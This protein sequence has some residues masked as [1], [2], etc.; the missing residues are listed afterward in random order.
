MIRTHWSGTGTDIIADNQHI[1]RL[2][3]DEVRELVLQIL[4]FSPRKLREEIKVW[5][6][7]GTIDTVGNLIGPDK[8][9]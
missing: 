1:S 9:L 8:E 2:T 6:D 4:V 3:H 7:G 5:L